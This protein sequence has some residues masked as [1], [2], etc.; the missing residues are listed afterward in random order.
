MTSPMQS[1]QNRLDEARQ[2]LSLNVKVVNTSMRAWVEDSANEGSAAE[3]PAEPL[4]LQFTTKTKYFD[5]HPFAVRD[6]LSHHPRHD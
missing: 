1:L 2:D 3:T 4:S 6:E 5:G